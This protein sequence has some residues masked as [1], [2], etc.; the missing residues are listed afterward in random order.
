M[1][2]Q[3]CPKC[4]QPNNESAS[5]CGQCGTA[6]QPAQVN[7][8]TPII[9]PPPIPRGGSE[10][11]AILLAV[12]TFFFGII[13]V[14]VLFAVVDTATGKRIGE[15]WISLGALVALGAAALVYYLVKRGRK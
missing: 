2:S 15:S 9:A 12:G 13:L 6:L 14:S 8:P 4:N 1:A 10:S 3:I 11:K 7:L 5:F